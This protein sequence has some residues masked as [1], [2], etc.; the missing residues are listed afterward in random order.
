[1]ITVAHFFAGGGGGI[2]ASEILGHESVLAVEIERDCC[3][4][5]KERKR[6]GWFPE[7]HI[8]CGDIDTFNA[9]PWKERVDCVS[10]GF[11]C[12]DISSCG[13]GEGIR[14]QRSGLFF[15]ALRSIDVIRPSIIFLENS[16]AIRTRG[17]KVVVRSLV[18]R[19][20]Y[21]RDG[22]LAA[23]HVG[24]GHKRSRWWCLAAN[25]EGLWKL[26]CDRLAYEGRFEASGGKTSS[27]NNGNTKLKKKSRKGG[28]HNGVRKH[29]SAESRR[30]PKSNGNRRLSESA[31]R[32]HD[33]LQEA[34]QSFGIS[35]ESAESIQA[36]AEYTKTHGWLP[37]DVGICGM[38]YGLADGMDQDKRKGSE[39]ARIKA[40]GN[41]QVPL[42]A[43]VAWAILAGWF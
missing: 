16:P 23:A 38:V 30:N 22:S 7:M 4:I 2:L 37:T 42:Q 25:E 21:W 9:N 32:L 13:T 15:S 39:A 19:G 8:E 40:C 33:G 35:I 11:P 18:E 27:D 17:R 34:V 26:E 28:I 12:Q 41:G 43:A 24:A 10:M 14:G 20:Y 6:E 31:S 29:S 5:L 1:M 36:A 3:E